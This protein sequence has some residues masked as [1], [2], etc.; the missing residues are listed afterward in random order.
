[1]TTVTL[2][3][4]YL[5]NLL[6]V[7]PNPRYC[8]L[9]ESSKSAHIFGRPVPEDVAWT[10]IDRAQKKLDM[11]P[12]RL[13]V[14]MGVVSGMVATTTVH[15]LDVIKVRLQLFPKKVAT[16][17]MLHRIMVCEGTRGLYAGLTAGL[18][19]QLT[20]TGS[21]LFVYNA[22]YDKYKKDHDKDPDFTARLR[23]AVIAGLVGA[24]MGTPSEIGLVRMI[25]V[26]RLR[27]SRCSPPCSVACKYVQHPENVI[28]KLLRIARREGVATW[29]RG[30]VPTVIRSIFVTT[31]QVGVYAEVRKAFT[32][33]EF[34]DT[35]IKL[36]L[37][38]AVISSLFSA[39]LSLPVD[40]VKTRYQSYQERHRRS[41]DILKGMLR[42]KGVMYLWKGFLPYY[43]R[44]V[45]HTV[46]TYVVLDE[47][48]DVYVDFQEATLPKR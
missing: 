35:G 6:Y 29:W 13:K 14:A 39:F 43:I 23:I 30:A 10:R 16:T 19:R 18:L 15:P 22:L 42:Y 40:Q 3:E 26:G 2:N 48:I 25:E 32:R 24:F 41:V 44:Q 8:I 38:T 47:L 17:K 5:T 21:R 33:G 46:I 11:I 9:F 34:M 28:L 1:M 37:Y 31:T 27:R 4:P 36:H 12:T 20:Y 7:R 45:I